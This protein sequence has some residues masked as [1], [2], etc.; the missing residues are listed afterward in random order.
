MSKLRAQLKGAL[1]SEHK[2]VFIKLEAKYDTQEMLALPILYWG[3]DMGHLH[4]MKQRG[5]LYEL[6]YVFNVIYIDSYVDLHALFKKNVNLLIKNESEKDKE[7][8]DDIQVQ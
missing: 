7:I 2:K 3:G 4:E 1:L 5:Y 8:L 6:D